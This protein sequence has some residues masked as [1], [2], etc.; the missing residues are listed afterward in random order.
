M[1]DEYSIRVE[2]SFKDIAPESWNMLSG[3]S[4]LTRTDDYNPF[5]SHAF[6]S[7]MEESGSATAKTGWRGHHLLLEDGEGELK[8]A[9]PAYLKSHSQGEPAALRS[10]SR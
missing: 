7:S 8:G 6:L 1:S 10:F 3:T 9:I 5:I 4:K 2:Q